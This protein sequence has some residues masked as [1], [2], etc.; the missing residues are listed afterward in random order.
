M[1]NCIVLRDGKR[2]TVFKAWDILES[3]REYMGDEAEIFFKNVFDEID[4]LR[5]QIEELE[6]DCKRCSYRQICDCCEDC[7][8]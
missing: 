8:N 1:P 5:N 7:I 2:I 3:V 4:E 6:S